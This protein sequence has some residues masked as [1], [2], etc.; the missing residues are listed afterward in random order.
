MAEGYFE[1]H[2]SWD[3]AV[4][5][6]V[7]LTSG[8]VAAGTR[9]REVRR[10]AGRQAAGFTVTDAAEPSRFALSSTSGPFALDRSYEF[11][12]NGAGCTVSF[13]FD[14]RPK[15]AM[16]LAFPLL[17]RTIAAQVRAN[18]GRIPSAVSKAGCPSR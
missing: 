18:I 1:H 17:R 15:A 11:K 4:V 16:R 12:P 8:P 3:P 6:M 9:G 5:E 7:K 10:F 13:S 2:S 14:M